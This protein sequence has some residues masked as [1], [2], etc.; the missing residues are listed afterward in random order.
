MLPYSV[1]CE[2]PLP[3]DVGFRPLTIGTSI[4]PQETDFP[5]T[6]PWTAE[7]DGSRSG[8][9]SS[10]LLWLLNARIDIDQNGPISTVS[11]LLGDIANEIDDEQLVEA[12]EQAQD[13]A[14]I[15]QLAALEAKLLEAKDAVNAGKKAVKKN[16]DPIVEYLLAVT[17]LDEFTCQA[18]GLPTRLNNAKGL[19]TGRGMNATFMTCSLS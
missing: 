4:I 17:L 19:F 16:G 7:C 14:Y 18:L 10:T 6:R 8:K 2:D 11:R 13:A 3:P 9:R 15:A 5:F 12:G 1:N